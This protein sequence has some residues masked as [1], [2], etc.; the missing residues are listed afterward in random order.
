[1]AHRVSQYSR[2]SWVVASVDKGEPGREKDPVVKEQGWGFNA[3][4]RLQGWP[5]SYLSSHLY[6]KEWDCLA[7]GC[8]LEG[9]LVSQNCL[10]PKYGVN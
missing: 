6:V 10:D 3:G 2:T 8:G 4:L 1:M 5:Y 7:E 9:L